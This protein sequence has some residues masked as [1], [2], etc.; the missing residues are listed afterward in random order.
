[1]TEWQPIETAKEDPDT[2][3]EVYAPSF[4]G[5]DAVVCLCCWHPDGGWCICQLR[6]VTHWRPHNPPEATNG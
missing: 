1:M 5:L 3:V 2:V 6:N 4:E